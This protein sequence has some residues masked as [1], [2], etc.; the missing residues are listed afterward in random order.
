LPAAFGQD[1]ANVQLPTIT[2]SLPA[3]VSPE[4]GQINYFMTGLF[5]GYGKFVKTSKG[6]TSY[7][8]AA[9]VDGK[10][11]ANVKNRFLFSGMRD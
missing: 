7:E 3:D 10:P 4:A 5:G 6:M 9:S 8:I 1:D 11:A 2:L